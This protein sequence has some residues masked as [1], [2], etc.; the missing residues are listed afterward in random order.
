MTY[1]SFIVAQAPEM[2]EKGARLDMRS[3]SSLMGSGNQLL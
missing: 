1:W 2:S 3:P